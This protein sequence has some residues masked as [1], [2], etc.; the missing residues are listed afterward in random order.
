MLPVLTFSHALFLS[1]DPIFVLF[2]TG[3][4]KI[5]SNGLGLVGLAINTLT[6][7]VDDVAMTRYTSYA[8]AQASEALKAIL[9]LGRRRSR[10]GAG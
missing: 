7:A 10:D 2:V 5:T 4:I 8:E 1:K 6:L 9:K 3:I